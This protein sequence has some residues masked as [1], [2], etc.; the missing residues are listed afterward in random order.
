MSDAQKLQKR[1]LRQ[2]CRKR[3]YRDPHEILCR[4]GA[5]IA[6]GNSAGKKQRQPAYHAGITNKILLTLAVTILVYVPKPRFSSKY[7]DVRRS[8]HRKHCVRFTLGTP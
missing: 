4:K 1:I 8:P 5:I 2:I 3:G 7:S 6:R